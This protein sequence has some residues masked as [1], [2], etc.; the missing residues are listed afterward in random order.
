MDKFEGR[1]IWIEFLCKS[2]SGKTNE[3]IVRT[4]TDIFLGNIKWDTR[5]RKYAFYPMANTL[6]EEVCLEDIARFLKEQTAKHK[7]K[8]GEK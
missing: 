1:W 5:W 8:G 2:V 4:K 6:Y 7:V 3:Y